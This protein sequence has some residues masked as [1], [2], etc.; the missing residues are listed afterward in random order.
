ML[1]S[2]TRFFKC[3]DWKDNCF[4]LRILPCIY[5]CN[6]I[7]HGTGIS[8][9]SL[10]S[11]SERQTILSGILPS[12]VPIWHI[13][14]GVWGCFFSLQMV[15]ACWEGSQEPADTASHLCSWIRC[16]RG[17]S[18]QLHPS[19]AELLCPHLGVYPKMLRDHGLCHSKSDYCCLSFLSYCSRGQKNGRISY[20]KEPRWWI[21][22]RSFIL[23]VRRDWKSMSTN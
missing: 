15:R 8:H 21:R 9:D 2:L 13:F 23:Y 14:K 22:S 6:C 18:Y 11:K 1:K 5:D 10:T 16:A 20:F 4:S 19:L 12:N 17:S 3:S 7:I